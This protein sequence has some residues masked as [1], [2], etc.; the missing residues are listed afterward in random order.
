MLS[1]AK[2][3]ESKLVD[4]FFVGTSGVPCLAMLVC[5][6]LGLTKPRQSYVGRPI[7]GPVGWPTGG[8]TSRHSEYQQL[9]WGLCKYAKSFKGLDDRYM[10]SVLL[11]KVTQSST[12]PV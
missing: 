7:N 8:F 1:G 5:I 10:L 9:T 4:Y 6:H 2:N 3:K 11:K 12:I